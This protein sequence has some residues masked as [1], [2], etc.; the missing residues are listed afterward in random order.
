MPL[1]GAVYVARVFE[2][3]PPAQRAHVK[4]GRAACRCC[5]RAGN[6]RPRRGAG[7]L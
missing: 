7:V 4:T 3:I 1:V 5:G 6:Q 2:A